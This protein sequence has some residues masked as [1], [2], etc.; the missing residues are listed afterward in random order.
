MVALREAIEHLN[1]GGVLLLFAHG[2]VEPDPECMLG[3][4]ESIQDWSHSIEI[5]LR[6]VPATKLQILSVS[7]AILPRFYNS[8][9]ARLRKSPAAR[10]KLAEFLQVINSVV[11]PRSEAA[12]LHISVSEPIHVEMFPNEKMMSRII[13]LAMDKMQKHMDWIKSLPT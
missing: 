8:P 5:M 11:A 2:E 6:K 10:Q 9:I 12:N 3:A 4:V 1:K 13:E 7:G